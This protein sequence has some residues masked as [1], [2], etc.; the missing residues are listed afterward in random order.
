MIKKVVCILVLMMSINL[1]AKDISK[2]YG[3]VFIYDAKCPYCQKM[4]PIVADIHNEYGL[5]LYAISPSGAIL[6]S[7][8]HETNGQVSLNEDIAQ[9]YYG[10]N[11]VRFPLLVLQELNG[12][13]KHFVI[14]N[15]YT[16]KQEVE[17]VLNSYLNY[18]K[19]EEQI[20]EAKHI[21]SIGESAMKL[22]PL[23]YDDNGISSVNK[24]PKMLNKKDL[25]KFGKSV[26]GN[27]YIDFS[28]E[29]EIS[30]LEDY[31]NKL[32]SLKVDNLTR[33]QKNQVN[34]EI[35]K[36]LATTNK[37]LKKVLNEVERLN[38][39]PKVLNCQGESHD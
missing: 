37:K 13:M 11:P 33:E 4:A 16:P 24:L 15:G 25:K 26:L 21:Q 12:E 1:F 36:A 14:A 31:L 19:Q 6:G 30:S 9:K 22:Q 39:L 10:S 29:N 34:K 38:Q 23:S 3:L 28:I 32:K 2:E 18:F 17:K 27:K 7:M 35:D 8:S 20:K 5:G